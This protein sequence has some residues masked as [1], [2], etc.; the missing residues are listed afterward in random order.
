MQLHAGEKYVVGLIPKKVA[1]GVS[2][3]RNMSDDDIKQLHNQYKTLATES[4]D[5]ENIKDMKKTIA[6]FLCL[7]LHTQNI[8][9]PKTIF[10][11]PPDNLHALRDTNKIEK[12][13]KQTGQGCIGIPVEEKFNTVEDETKDDLHLLNQALKEVPDCM[14]EDAIIAGNVVDALERLRNKNEFLVLFNQ[15]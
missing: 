1:E 10:T 13:L 7:K 14:T 3:L 4:S 6:F 11:Y 8:E 5:D 15:K 2:K 9:S 12:F